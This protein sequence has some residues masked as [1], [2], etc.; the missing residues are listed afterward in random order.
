MIADAATT[1]T[2]PCHVQVELVSEGDAINE[3]FI[4]V[5]GTLVSYRTSSPWNSEVRAALAARCG[6]RR[7]A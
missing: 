7:A 6:R 2:S 4:V 1:D 5:S 3:M